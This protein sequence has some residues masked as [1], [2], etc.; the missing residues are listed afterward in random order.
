M[1]ADIDGIYT[2]EKNG[3]DD[4]GNG[5]R[6]NPFKT[7]LQAMRH[8]KVEP[9]STIYVDSKD[10]KAEGSY[11]VAAKSQLKKIHKIFAREG[12]KNA[13]KQRREAEDAEK[14]LEN[15]EDARKI[16]IEENP[17]LPAARRIRISHGEEYRG[18]RI[19]VYGWVHRLR[20]QGKGLIFITLRDGTGFL[21][22]VLTDRLCQT[23]EALVLST[24]SSVLLC[25]VLKPVPHG[26]SVRK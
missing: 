7:I 20:R 9:F 24:E 3:N 8:A 1:L 15:L 4:N 6:E 22:C 21:Q 18:E 13:D 26:K 10:P 25:G 5:T 19:K 23:Y 2:S 14:R 16:K 12:H 17:N 11:E